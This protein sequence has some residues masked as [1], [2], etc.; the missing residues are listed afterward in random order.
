MNDAEKPSGV[1]NATILVAL[2]GII[3]IYSGYQFNHFFIIWAI[4]LSPLFGISLIVLGILS[5]CTSLPIWQQKLW[6]TKLTTVIG[7]AVCGTF[8]IF[9]F[10]LVIIF[11]ALWYYAVLDF[12]K[13]GL[14]SKPTE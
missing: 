6:A 7:V 9:G 3:L 8:V 1:K 12:I 2:G 13:K 11:F 14:P 4:P 10:Y 5:L